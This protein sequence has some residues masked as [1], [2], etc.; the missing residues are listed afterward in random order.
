MPFAGTRE[1]LLAHLQALSRDVQNATLTPADAALVRAVFALGLARLGPTNMQFLGNEAETLQVPTATLCQLYS[2]R[3]EFLSAGTESEAWQRHLA[4]TLSSLEHVDD[5]RVVEWLAKRSVFLSSR[6]P[7]PSLPLHPGL[8]AVVSKAETSACALDATIA[9]VYEFPNTYDF[10]RAAAVDRLIN[11]GLGTANDDVIRS[12]LKAAMEGAPT[13]NIGAHRLGAIDACLRAARA[14]RDGD[15]V[16][17]CCDEIVIVTQL[18]K[19]PS[20]RDLLVAV[21]PA[22]LALVLTAE[23]RAERFL[24]TLLQVADSASEPEPLLATLSSGFRV[25]NQVE[26]AKGLLTKALDGALYGA[27]SHVSR[28][29]AAVAVIDELGNWPLEWASGQYSALLLELHRFT[30]GFTVNRFFSTHQILV[31]ERIM[32]VFIA[33]RD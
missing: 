30:D 8:E 21:R 5:R 2:A 10:E 29:E 33:G 18:K 7:A 12:T 14:L 31:T 26:K 11:S 24:S 9:A 17:R 27:K 20:L 28:Y 13:I 32:R 25:L 19:P 16:G 6:A 15:A 23:E 22:I 3:L 4:T 1:E